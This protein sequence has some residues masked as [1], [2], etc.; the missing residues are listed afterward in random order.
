MIFYKEPNSPTVYIEYNNIP[1]Y[2]PII[3]R[4]AS[5]PI[6]TDSTLLLNEITLGASLPLDFLKE[7]KT[8][9]EYRVRFGT[10]LLTIVR[11]ILER[12]SCSLPTFKVEA[13]ADHVC[14]T[15]IGDDEHTE[16]I[17]SLN[18]TY[19]YVSSITFCIPTS[20]LTIPMVNIIRFLIWYYGGTGI[21]FERVIE[22]LLV[23]RNVSYTT[24]NTLPSVSDRP[25]EA[26]GLSFLSVNEPLL[27]VNPS[28]LNRLEHFPQQAKDCVK[29]VR[30]YFVS[31]DS[32]NRKEEIEV[33]DV[34]RLVHWNT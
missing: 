6:T 12:N 34:L 13:T 2:L 21:E 24:H 7:I 30:F 20:G 22:E 4:I 18:Y 28:T 11:A 23:N 32:L 10:S 19:G 3:Y 31:S 29:A 5:R 26:D 17:V 27:Y 33:D 25:L 14:A 16:P 9:N 8:L 1:I 15:L